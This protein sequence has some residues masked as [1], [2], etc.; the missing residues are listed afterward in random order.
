MR[1]GS[2][3]L[4]QAVKLVDPAERAPHKDGLPDQHFA[5]LR[6]FIIKKHR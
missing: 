2:E 1:N 6:Q 3:K 4:P 5:N